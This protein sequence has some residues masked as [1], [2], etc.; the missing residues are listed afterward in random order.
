MNATRPSPHLKAACPKPPT[1]RRASLAFIHKPPASRREPIRSTSQLPSSHPQ[2]PQGGLG[3]ISDQNIR[4]YFVVGPAAA[5]AA[6]RE[7]TT[8]VG[9]LRVQVDP[10]RHGEELRSGHPAQFSSAAGPR[11]R[12]VPRRAVRRRGEAADG[13]DICCSLNTEEEAADRRD[14]CCSLN[15]TVELARFLSHKYPQYGVETYWE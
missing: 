9:V 8:V 13:R 2:E 11:R 5:A 4:V 1:P 14:I 6:G 15:M 12:P 7:A 3:P 10:R